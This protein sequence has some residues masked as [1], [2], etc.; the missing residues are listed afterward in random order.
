[1][2]CDHPNRTRLLLPVLTIG[3]YD[4][5]VQYSQMG[6]AVGYTCADCNMRWLE[7]ADG[8]VLLSVQ[9]VKFVTVGSVDGD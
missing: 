8:K 9:D 5:V 2:A 4:H 6:A 7:D 1:M 3:Q